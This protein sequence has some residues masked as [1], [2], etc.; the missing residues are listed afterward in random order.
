MDTPYPAFTPSKGNEN[1]NP[2]NSNL[3]LSSHKVE[4]VSIDRYG[5]V[6]RDQQIISHN[7][8]PLVRVDVAPDRLSTRNNSGI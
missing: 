4:K 2:E 3:G 8:A 7:F 5:G 1:Y 6:H